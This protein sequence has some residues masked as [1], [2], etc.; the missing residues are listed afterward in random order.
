MAFT[1]MATALAASYPPKDP[2]HAFIQEALRQAVLFRL[3]K[4]GA[5][6]IA[7]DVARV[8]PDTWE[9]VSRYVVPPYP[10]TLF[11]NPYQD[12]EVEGAG[13]M[14]GMRT[15]V[16]IV[17]NQ[18]IPLFQWNDFA[19]AYPYIATFGEP[20]PDVPE[21]KHCTQDN[22]RVI[23]DHA[24]K[25]W[26]R[27]GEM[28]KVQEGVTFR[29]ATIL[30]GPYLDSA[31]TI[32]NDGDPNSHAGAC[33]ERIGEGLVQRMLYVLAYLNKRPTH[34]HVESRKGKTD[35]KMM[36]GGTFVP[37]YYH[38]VVH[39]LPDNEPR[40]NKSDPGAWPGP[41]KMNHPVRGH[42]RTYHRGTEKEFTIPIE[43]HRRGDERLGV[44][45]SE[46]VI[47]GGSLAHRVAAAISREPPKDTGGQ[48]GEDKTHPAAEA[49]GEG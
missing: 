39:I 28:G 34:V 23:L 25:C 44:K 32:F 6:A 33:V 2:G 30:A 45:S 3:E 42:V 22:D 38:S 41:R 15:G 27:D 26:G 29:G 19:G 40:K 47:V 18:Y 46:Y 14:R 21:L 49:A 5:Q 7:T 36:V 37:R 31:E 17:G 48:H 9:G 35:G 13:I 4:A 1:P 8:L 11:E 20:Y 24:A 10:V 16:L 12:V 43:P